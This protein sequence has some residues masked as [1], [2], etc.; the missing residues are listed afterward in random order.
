MTAAANGGGR[1]PAPAVDRDAR[2]ALA[3]AAI[4]D[5]G[6]LIGVRELAELWGIS[7]QAVGRRAARGT[8]PPPVKTVGR[9]RVWLRAQIEPRRDHHP[10]RAA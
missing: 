10:Q 6:G 9:V 4:E 1:A 7:E 8:L 3:L 2:V 5:A